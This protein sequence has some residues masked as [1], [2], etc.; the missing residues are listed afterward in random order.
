MKYRLSLITLQKITQAITGAVTSLYI[1]YYLNPIEQGYY[2]LI[3]SLITS[4]IIFEFGLSTFILQRCHELSID[5][6]IY[7]SN[8]DIRNESQYKYLC[9]FNWTFKYYC[10]LAVFTSLILLVI[11][12]YILSNKND[13]IEINKWLYPWILTIFAIL[14]FIPSIGLMILIEGVGYVNQIYM[15]K[16]LQYVLACIT[17][18]FLII[19]SKGLYAIAASFIIT[20]SISYFFIFTKFKG[21]FDQRIK[22]H[23]QYS[24]IT[25]EV[26]N[27]SHTFGVI[28]ISEYL[29]LNL[30]IILA[31]YFINPLYAGKLGLI[32][33]ITNVLAAIS[34]SLYAANYQRLISEIIKGSQLKTKIIL[35]RNIYYFTVLY[36]MGSILL[37]ILTSEVYLISMRMPSIVD[38]II[39][40]F[41]YFLFHISSIFI[42]FLRGKK[43]NIFNTISISIVCFL[44]ILVY[45]IFIEFNYL[46]ISV[47]LTNTII[48]LFIYI[49]IKKSE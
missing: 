3:A 44:M 11:G 23:D 40:L 8:F 49:K 36:I 10:R 42:S 18:I 16:I 43:E 26:K 47:G 6:D 19:N 1:I 28:Y 5:F 46:I 2:F 29:Q 20:S 25:K 13:V 48:L 33:R 22:N 45:C 7:R 32:I 9:L 38:L 15:I 14:L 4:Y 21:I 12:F 41:S 27:N 39:V 30:P 24:L 31:F 35:S 37:I 17:S 34:M